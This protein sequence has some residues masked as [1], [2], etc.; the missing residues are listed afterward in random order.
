MRRVLAVDPYLLG[1]L[2]FITTSGKGKTPASA[3]SSLRFRR[4][5]VLHARTLIGC[6]R[7]LVEPSTPNAWLL[8]ANRFSLQFPTHGSAWMYRE[9][10]C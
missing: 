7:R 4:A 9:D 1:S 6:G 8:F 5:T 10:I 3:R 2:F